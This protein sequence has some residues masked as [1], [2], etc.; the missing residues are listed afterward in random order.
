MTQNNK[1]REWRTGPFGQTINMK[2]MVAQRGDQSE[3]GG[4]NG[5]QA[6]SATITAAT[7]NTAS[8]IVLRDAS[9][10]FSAGTITATLS[11]NATTASNG[12][13]TSVSAGTGISVNTTTGGVTVTNSGVTSVNGSTG[14]VTVA[15][16]GAGA[17]VSF[18]TTGGF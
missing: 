10:N 9:G 1:K 3:L 11:G 17:F 8:T 15:A 12:G 14:A 4:E 5:I 16:G 18:G 6:N 2:L 7:A 13:V